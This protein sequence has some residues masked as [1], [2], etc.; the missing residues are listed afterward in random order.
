M[1][2]EAVED[3]MP[4]ALGEMRGDARE[5][6]RC[7]QKLFPKRT[8]VAGVVAGASIRR[9][10]PERLEGLSVV[11]ESR[12]FNRAVAQRIGT[13]ESLLHHERER[14]ALLKGE[15]IDVPLKDI[16]ELLYELR[17]LSCRPQRVVERGVDARGHDGVDLLL[18]C[19]AMLYLKS[20]GRSQRLDLA[21]ARHFH[22]HTVDVAGCGVMEADEMSRSQPVEIDDS[23]QLSRQLRGLAAIDSAFHENGI[24]RV[25]FFQRQ[26][27]R[28][29]G[30][31]DRARCREVNVTELWSEGV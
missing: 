5:L 26:Q 8:G 16:D 23:R 12:R 30:K 20:A 9:F 17:S 27:D 18:H 1:R 29:F 15:E 11:N 24:E 6:Q 22:L 10:L 2:L 28:V 7:A 13:R 19:L 4:S 31:R 3:R 21:P 14:V 25:A